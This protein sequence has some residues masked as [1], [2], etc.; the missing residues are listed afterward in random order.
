MAT[1]F[2]SSSLLTIGK[3]AGAFAAFLIGPGFATGQE[4]MQFFASEG[5]RGVGGAALF[6]VVCSYVSI[7]LLLAGQAHGF[8]NLE[9]VF[10]YYTGP[11]VGRLYTWYTMVLIFSVYAVMLAAAGADVHES[12]G[13]PVFIGSGLMALAVLAALF[14]GL[15]ALTAVIGWAGPVL[16]VLLIG[17]AI[18]A[19]VGS[20]SGTEAGDVAAES[21]DSLRASSAWW[22]SALLY[23]GVQLTALFSFLP[24]VGATIEHRKEAIIAGFVGPALVFLVLLVLILALVANLTTVTG[25]M[26]PT[27]HLAE[28]VHPLLAPVFALIL[29]AGIL[30]TCAPLVW[31]LLARFTADA[32]RR[33]RA[34]AVALTAI[35]YIGSLTLPFDRLLNLIYPTIGWSGMILLGFMLVRQIRNRSL[36]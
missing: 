18:A 25:K 9:E 23:T 36:V 6:L 2:Q 7:S 28:S 1:A 5:L 8:K 21:L 29:L 35:G 11:L 31:V 13:L 15:R 12:Y 26:I 10:R 24:S 4:V 16:V 27:L 22:L 14:F 32:G 30:T 17:I 20:A 33:Y 34:L 19:I 3:V